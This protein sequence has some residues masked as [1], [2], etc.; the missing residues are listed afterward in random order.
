[1]QT[2]VGQ[3]DPNW[4]QAPLLQVTQ[5]QHIEHMP[6]TLHGF[7]LPNRI[8]N[9]CWVSNKQNES[10]DYQIEYVSVFS[11]SFKYQGAPFP[12]RQNQFCFK[13]SHEALTHQK[14]HTWKSQK[15][16]GRGTCAMTVF[17]ALVLLLLHIVQLYNHEWRDDS[18]SSSRKW[19]HN[20]V[21]FTVAPHP[22]ISSLGAHKTSQVKTS[23]LD[24]HQSNSLLVLLCCSLHGNERFGG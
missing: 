7:Q 21:N 1:V 8:M 13:E 23:L 24:N 4:W 5:I 11:V 18:H 19:C 2:R 20:W 17:A 14:H 22:A 12:V 6:S 10:F 9:W 16:W 15:G 3:T